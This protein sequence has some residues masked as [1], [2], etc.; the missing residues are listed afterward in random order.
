MNIPHQDSATAQKDVAPHDT[1][2]PWG[3]GHFPP[4]TQQEACPW[5]EHRHPPPSPV[6]GG[7]GVA[8]TRWVPDSC[9]I[10]KTRDRFMLP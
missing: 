8:W 6:L 3:G 7:G 2:G 10:V 5:A 1:W 9:P 4:Q